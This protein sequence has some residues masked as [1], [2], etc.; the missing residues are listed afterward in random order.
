M[1]AFFDLLMT[2]FM[3]LG[4]VFCG[5]YSHALCRRGIIDLEDK[6]IKRERERGDD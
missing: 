6:E 5:Y 1:E 4:G 3:F 2:V